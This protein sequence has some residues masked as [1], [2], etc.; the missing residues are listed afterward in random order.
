MRAVSLPPRLN[1]Q[2]SYVIVALEPNSIKQKLAYEYL[3][4]IWDN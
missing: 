3:P 1:S 2:D 4:A